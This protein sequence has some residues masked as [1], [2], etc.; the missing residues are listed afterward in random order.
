MKSSSVH[1]EMCCLVDYNE[2]NSLCFFPRDNLSDN[3]ERN[4]K[5]RNR[6]LHISPSFH[7]CHHLRH[8]YLRS[9]R[10]KQVI[11][12]DKHGC[13]CLSVWKI[14]KMKG[15]LFLFLF[16]SR[17]HKYVW[18]MSLPSDERKYFH[19]FWCQWCYNNRP[20]HLC[21]FVETILSSFRTVQL[22]LTVTLSKTEIDRYVW[23]I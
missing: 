20:P 3:L 4:G 22:Q 8:E 23:G 6:Q 15:F 19:V 18:K 7:H 9:D 16:L 12:G 10:L 21:L 5:F 11:S 1:G 17:Q 13:L 2:H 14:G